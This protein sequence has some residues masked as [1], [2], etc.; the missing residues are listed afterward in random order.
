MPAPSPQT[1]SR[2]RAGQVVDRA[3]AELL[4]GPSGARDLRIVAAA[5]LD[6]STAHPS[7]VAHLLASGSQRLSALVREGE[8]RSLALTRLRRLRDLVGDLDDRG[9]RAGQLIA[10]VVTVSG[11]APA[12]EGEQPSEPASAV[13]RVS[14][15]GRELPALLRPAR[16]GAAGPGD[17]V[18]VIDGPVRVNPALTREVLARTA[19]GLD[20]TVELEP[21]LGDTAASG[22][23]FD[24]DPAL[25]RLQ[26]LLGP[27]PGVTLRRRLLLA[28]VSLDTELLVADL[29]RLLP[30]VPGHPVLSWVGDDWDLTPATTPH[31]EPGVA[32]EDVRTLIDDFCPLPLD[33]DQRRVLTR[34]LT[35]HGVA[36]DAPAG[37]GASTVAVAVACVAAAT[38]RRAAIVLPTRSAADILEERFF[39]LGLGE[40]VGLTAPDGETGGPGEAPRRAGPTTSVPVDAAV[41]D[42]R[43][44]AAARYAEGVAACTGTR[45]PWGVSRLQ[46]LDALAAAEL[47]G[48]RLTD[49]VLPPTPSSRIDHAEAVALADDLAEAVRLGAPTPPP[50]AWSGAVIDTEEQAD[51]ALSLARRLR[52]GVVEEARA[53]IAQLAESTGTTAPTSL[54]EVRERHRLFTGVQR[55]LDRLRP[56]V[57]EVPMLDLVA[58]T[59]DPA[60]REATDYPM[61]PTTRWRLV[62]RARR[63]ARPGLQLETP[64]LHRLLS[65]AAALR[66]EWQRIAE[67]SGWAHLPP[68]SATLV[69]GIDELVGTCEALAA[70]HPTLVLDDL[71]LDDLQALAARLVADGYALAT[72]P[73][74][75]TLVRRLTERGCGPLLSAL[76]GIP[77]AQLTPESAHAELLLAWWTGVVEATS[78]GL[79]ADAAVAAA[80]EHDRAE[81]LWRSGARHRVLAAH[82]AAGAA[83]W[84]SPVRVVVPADV[85]GWSARET[86]DV[87][88]L[89]DGGRTAFAEACG[90]VSRTAQVVVLGDLA[91]AQPRSALAVLAKVL[92]PDRLGVRHR[93]A[94][95]TA[96][97]VVEAAGGGQ[98]RSAP[99]ARPGRGVTFTHLPDATGL[100]GA[101]VDQLESTQAE[102][103][104]VVRLTVDLAVR[105]TGLDE[106][107]SLAVLGLTRQHAAAVAAGV[108]RVVAAY[109]AL[110]DAFGPHRPEPVVVASAEQALGLER[111]VVVLSVGF[112]RTPHGRVLHRFA[113][114]DEAGGPAA[115]ATAVSRSRETLHVVSGLRS[116]D[117]DPVRL[118][119][120]GARALHRVLGAAEAASRGPVRGAAVGGPAAAATTR[121]ALGQRDSAAPGV[122]RLLADD[123]VAG[124]LVVRPTAPP[125]V[126]L[127]VDALAESGSSGVGR[128]GVLTRPLAV[129]LDV[130]HPVAADLTVKRHELL[131]LGWQV[132]VVA[133]EEVAADRDAVLA[134]LGGRRA[135]EPTEAEDQ[136]VTLVGS[137]PTEEPALDAALAEPVDTTTSPEDD[138]GGSANGGG[139]VAET[140]AAVSTAA[141]PRPT[142]PEIG[143]RVSGGASVEVS[144]R[145]DVGADNRTV[146][147]VST[148]VDD[149]LGV[150]PGSEESDAQVAGSD[151]ATAIEDG[152]EPGQAGVA[153]AAAAGRSRPPGTVLPDRSL[154]DSD[155]AWGD[156]ADSDDRLV[157]ERPPHW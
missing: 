10:G 12:A 125:G 36:V 69:Q 143:G 47:D 150:E 104:H 112:G 49:V 11:A 79:P 105:L 144:A 82:A 98:A 135:E 70:H 132:E 26:A 22:S 33:D 93:P 114:L 127:A 19:G 75:A 30:L 133:V 1:P 123:L 17:A 146:A 120:D 41:A 68:G 119:T 18:V 38:G 94:D 8:A 84:S 7:G 136:S 5:V 73:Q 107:R 52:D 15:R 129:L 89:D 149:Q 44:R 153:D 20:L 66:L 137:T 85:A 154:T 131:D 51:N 71:G 81:E 63:L 72:Q 61:A 139:S 64:E 55:V 155:S 151:A 90:A 28:P 6:L 83:H 96:A 156:E 46:A 24:P 111:D 118:R 14:D 2:H 37:T 102:V 128:G 78:A 67:G 134:R 25:D 117:L 21:V 31:V 23:A 100:P 113:A 54:A 40:L 43:R 147:A 115:L 140:G 53:A 124:G 45:R 77:P 27:V 4:D 76:A 42:L 13:E 91:V 148:H 88:I 3:R 50:T 62:R 39:S 126:A 65:Q 121:A 48:T 106:P 95:A 92:V 101:G 35:G 103:E 108:R 138:Q 87:V 99:V 29:E 32:S 145:P 109:P 116:S 60:F 34:V 157:V 9:Q 152:S 122:V 56:D 142:R 80:A 86:A 130:D 110:A 97:A 57:F 74:R 58:A 59:A 16:V 141:P